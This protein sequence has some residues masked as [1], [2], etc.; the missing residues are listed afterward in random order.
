MGSNDLNFNFDYE[1]PSANNNR[2]PPTN[3][4]LNRQGSIFALT[5][6]EFQNSVGWNGK[7]FGSM[8]L[9]ELLKSILSAEE[10]NSSVPSSSG[11]GRP[12]EAPGQN[13]HFQCQ[14]SLILPRTLS[15]KTVDEIWRDI[16]KECSTEK[17][18]VGTSG[19]AVLPRSQKTLG[20]ITLEEFLV[21]VV[22][23][24]ED[25]QMASE[26]NAG[27]GFLEKVPCAADNPKL[28]IGSQKMG[29]EPD[30]MIGIRNPDNVNPIPIQSSS[31]LPLNV[32][33]VLTNQQQQI[34][35]KQPAIPFSPQVPPSSS[36]LLV[37]PRIQTGLVGLTDQVMNNISVHGT[38]AFQGGMMRMVGSGAGPVSAGFMG[39]SPSNPVS[40]DGVERNSGDTSSVSPVPY[41]FN[42]GMKRSKGSSALD[43][44]VERRQKRMIKNRESAARSRARKQAYTMELEA[45][46]AKLKEENEELRK[47]Q[48]EIMEVQKNKVLEMMDMQ[49]GAKRRK[50]RRTQTSPW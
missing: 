37:I 30:N 1:P 6:D 22:A 16:S 43:K 21:K 2:H 45:E 25:A 23:V 7:D 32:N 4:P 44:V 17:D 47:K 38:A 12:D 39:G 13:G 42:G 48:A 9:D 8:N 24:R 41:M 14:G 18:S 33:R 10:N 36:T 46:I 31:N 50:L 11:V 15:Q 29:G 40:S 49:G 3:A 27:G 35:P 5:F 34:L 19:G 28:E 26:T 20:E